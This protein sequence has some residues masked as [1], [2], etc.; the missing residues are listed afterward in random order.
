MGPLTQKLLKELRSARKSNI[1]D[2]A[3]LR[4]ARKAQRQLS[5]DL[6]AQA[7]A[8]PPQHGAWMEHLLT[9][10]NLGNSML[11]SRALAKLAERIEAAHE[12]Y[13][14]GGPPMSPI[15]DSVFVCWY[16]LDLGVGPRRETLFSMLADLAAP[17]GLPTPLANV[18]RIAADSSLGI[19]RVTKLGEARVRLESLA[20]G[21]GVDAALP[22]GMDPTGPLWL[23]RLLPP[24]IQGP[25]DWVVWTTPYHLEDTSAEADWRAYFE[26]VAPE[27]KGRVERVTRHF[28][29]PPK[30]SFWLDYI[31]D[32]YAG[33]RAESGA[34][35]LTG[36]P[37]R[38]ETLPHSEASGAQAAREPKTQS[39][40][41]RVHTRLFEQARR[42]GLDGPD[43]AGIRRELRAPLEPLFPD[44]DRI[45]SAAFSCYAALDA[46]GR[47]ALDQ[48]VE[49][50]AELPADEREVVHGLAA[51]WFS[52]FEILQV[53]LDEG[54]EVRD[55]LRRKRL[56]ILERAGTHAAATGDLVA[57]W[58]RVSD[59]DI[60]FEGALAHIPKMIATTFE[61]QLRLLRDQLAARTRGLGWKR[62]SAL[63]APYIC[64]LRDR[65]VQDLLPP[66]IS[67]T[68]LR[69]PLD[70]R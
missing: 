4:E 46:K 65:I 12:L 28:K 24:L 3:P 67:P 22:Q 8:F 10:T 13:M 55:L 53:R 25:P 30:A 50:V 60:R 66:G 41:E 57:G 5:E 29:R 2:L 14:P 20:T 44:S 18:L 48:L 33:V 37:D 32:A 6:R 45:L 34:V 59:S 23:T 19:Y 40:S 26:R 58:I 62:R 7:H 11:R 68:T 51:G 9:L 31:L 35:C 49:R 56:F 17:L 38:P 1:I 63:L 70:E 69:R 27:S 42:R 47:T 39:A 36:V 43:P 54:F 52:A 64:P 16:T 61:E 21:M 15:Y